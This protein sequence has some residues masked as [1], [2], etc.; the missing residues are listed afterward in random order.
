LKG[1]EDAQTV[2]TISNLAQLYDDEA[3]YQ[4]AERLDSE[5]LEAAP[6]S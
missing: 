3:K 1:V 2:A 6:R 4:Q 5:A